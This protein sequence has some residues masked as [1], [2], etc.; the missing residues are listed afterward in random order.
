MNEFEPK[1]NSNSY[2]KWNEVEAMANNYNK[3]VT[4]DNK[5]RAERNQQTMESI[6][7]NK[8]ASGLFRKIASSVAITLMLTATGGI[9]GI[10]AG[11]V[12]AEQ[13]K[14]EQLDKVTHN[15][16]AFIDDNGENKPWKIYTQPIGDDGA[17]HNEKKIYHDN[18]H[19]DTD[20]KTVLSEQLEATLPELELEKSKGIAVEWM[21][22]DSVYTAYDVDCD[23]SWNIV[24]RTDVNTAW[25]QGPYFIKDDK[26]GEDIPSSWSTMTGVEQYIAEKAESE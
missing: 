22:G 6:V 12:V 11:N 14:A 24:T 16:T 18:I 3:F 10:T 8:K 19:C 17:I 21:K 20:D 15:I 2:D 4:I 26:S 23:G 7:N 13:A 9:M 1:D 5:E 25:D